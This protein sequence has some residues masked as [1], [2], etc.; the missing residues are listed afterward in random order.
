[1]NSAAAQHLLAQH[2]SVAS[3]KPAVRAAACYRHRRWPSAH[4]GGALPR[5][6]HA[7]RC[8][9]G[10]N[11]RLALARNADPDYVCNQHDCNA[12]THSAAPAPPPTHTLPSPQSIRRRH[13]AATAV[14]TGP[15][16]ATGARP[17]LSPPMQR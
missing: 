3:T 8:A 2:R 15:K 14:P 16:V 9:D 11:T 17:D 4:T 1:M 5:L 13:D 10:A 6:G 7:A 12:V